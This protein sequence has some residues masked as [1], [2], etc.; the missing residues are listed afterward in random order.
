MQ[1]MEMQ[2]WK[3]TDKISGAEHAGMGTDGQ[4]FTGWQLNIGQ[5]F[6]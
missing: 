6:Q 3:M 2:D 5:K 4:K 1:H